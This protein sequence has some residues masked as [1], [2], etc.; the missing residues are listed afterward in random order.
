MRSDCSVWDLDCGVWDLDCGVWDL[1]CGVW[2]L[3]CGVWDLDI[4]DPGLR[5]VVFGIWIYLTLDSG[6]WNLGS[7]YT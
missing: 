1:D 5:I 2:D 3:D 7:G 4:P 6:L